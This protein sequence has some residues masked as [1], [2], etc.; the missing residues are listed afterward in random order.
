[1]KV[2]A[3]RLE[4]NVVEV[5]V[6][7]DSDQVNDAISRAYKDLSH[8]YRI[9]GFRPGKA[10]R[11]VIDSMFG[12]E[13]VLGHATQTLVEANE[14]LALNEA[15][16]VATSELRYDDNDLVESGKEYTYTIKVP[17]RPEFELTSYDPV[18]I[19]MPFPE[20]TEKE[21]DD[22][23]DM[24]KTFYATTE[25]AKR[26]NMAKK[27]SLVEIDMVCKDFEPFNAT[28]RLHE[29]G[30]GGLPEAFD[31]A[32]VGMKVGE[33]K[34]FP[35]TI[36]TGEDQREVEVT[37]TYK[38]LKTR[39]E[40]EVSDE[41]AKNLFGLETL[42]ELRDTLKSDINNQKQAQLP[43]LKENK[44][45]TEISWRLGDVEIDPAYLQ[46]VFQDL[47]RQFLDQLQAQGMTLDQYLQQSGLTADRFMM[48]LNMQ[49]TDVARESLAL[50]ALARH[51]KLEVTE[52][53]ITAE[54]ENAQVEDVEASKQQFIENGR[55]PA[56]RDF[57]MRS[58]AIKYLVEHAQVT[59][60]DDYK[61]RDAKL[62]EERR[63][64]MQ[65]KREEAQAAKEEKAAKKAPAKK[66][67][68][69][70]S[71]K[72]KAAD[73]EA[74]EAPAKKTASKKSAQKSEDAAN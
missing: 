7:I 52:E 41:F 35:V 22:Q 17:V 26:Q 48:D 44:C 24:F 43:E 74:G 34:T 45:L 63:E 57:L 62:F 2:T 70:K 58:K 13:G 69:K 20:A 60:C 37:V 42:A 16:V 49:A 54:F 72:E 33:E 3:K 73:A 21:I 25:D 46:S 28:D 71:L 6:T 5:V 55:M 27:D 8:R 38:K 29:L 15:N 9:P 10:P 65:K 68:A 11:P 36:G 56:L 59:E 50:D 32:I 61:E 39:V 51:L 4:G 40:P 18:E 47:A 12:K 64:L 67:A 66:S 23:I 19:N 53:D 1:M 30:K 14:P 31:K